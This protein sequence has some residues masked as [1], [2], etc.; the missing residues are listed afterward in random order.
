VVGKEVGEELG[1]IAQL[2]GLNAHAVSIGRTQSSQIAAV[3]QDPSPAPLQRVG[4]RHDR[5]WVGLQIPRRAVQEAL[6]EHPHVGPPRGVEKFA[7]P[8]VCRA[9]LLAQL[10]QS[11]GVQAVDEPG[12]GHQDVEVAC[13]PQ[14][15]SQL[16]HLVAEP[17]DLWIVE[18]PTKERQGGPE[19]PEADPGLVKRGGVTIDI[20]L[21]DVGLP[22]IE[23]L[24]GH[25]HDRGA[26]EAGRLQSDR[27][28]LADAHELGEVDGAGHSGR[29]PTGNWPTE[30]KPSPRATSTVL[31]GRASGAGVAP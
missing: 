20:D 4:R 31:S 8:H 30:V 28:C 11:A 7:H 29:V 19:A 5:G 22:V 2:L 9:A 16:A 13:V 10:G 18:R 12:L 14:W 3:A 24:A 17:L 6:H 1:A 23:A 26:R 21:A 25:G 15:E 27:P